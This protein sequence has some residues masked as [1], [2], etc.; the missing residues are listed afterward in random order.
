MHQHKKKK[1]NIPLCLCLHREGGRLGRASGYGHGTMDSGSSSGGL[2]VSGICGVHGPAL[3][4]QCK[5]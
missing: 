5:L 3:Q 2:S 1:K 4:V